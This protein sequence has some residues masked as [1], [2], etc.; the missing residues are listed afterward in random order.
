MNFKLRSLPCCGRQTLL[1]WPPCSYTI[2]FP[3]LLCGQDYDLLLTN[4]I[5]QRLWDVTSMI[6]NTCIHT[7]YAHTYTHMALS[8]Y[9][10]VETLLLAF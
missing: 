3:P 1:G 6:I 5:W 2:E 10:T 8:C 4:T 7:L 9:H